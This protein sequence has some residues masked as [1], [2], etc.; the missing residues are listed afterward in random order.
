MEPAVR[1]TK[2]VGH[3]EAK[4]AYEQA[5]ELCRRDAESPHTIP[6]LWGLWHIGYIQGIMRPAVGQA[7][8]LLASAEASQNQDHLLIAHCSL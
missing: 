8:E 1:A 4:R 3:P 6:L 2:G 5:Y 7:E